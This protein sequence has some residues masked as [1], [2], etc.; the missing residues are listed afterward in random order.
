MSAIKSQ[1]PFRWIPFIYYMNIDNMCPAYIKDPSFLPVV[2]KMSSVFVK[3]SLFRRCSWSISIL[4]GSPDPGGISYRFI[5]KVTM[6][7]G[8]FLLLLQG[9]SM[10]LHALLQ[11]L[12]VETVEE[13][14]AWWDFCLRV[15]YQPVTLSKIFFFELIVSFFA[16]RPNQPASP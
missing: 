15:C 7:V 6:T 3:K 9:I 12:G 16:F 14:H 13:E 5:V 1:F 11:V 2:I 8:Y 4:E 10:G